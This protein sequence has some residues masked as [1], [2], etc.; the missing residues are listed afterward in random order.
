MSIKNSYLEEKEVFFFKVFSILFVLCVCLYIRYF[1][2]V[3]VMFC[4]F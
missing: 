3:E 2:Q 4:L 1:F